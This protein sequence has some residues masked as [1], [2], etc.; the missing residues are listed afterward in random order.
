M[1]AD[2]CVHRQFN[3]KFL[4]HNGFSPADLCIF[5]HQGVKKNS[6][7]LHK[8]KITIIHTLYH[9]LIYSMYESVSYWTKITERKIM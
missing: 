4:M 1:Y 8:K 3:M 2:G 7:E 5:Y 6:H 9:V